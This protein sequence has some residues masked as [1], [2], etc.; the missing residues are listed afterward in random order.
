MG[1]RY[2]N[3]QDTE[4]NE[5]WCAASLS[6]FI[7]FCFCFQ[8]GIPARGMGPPTVRLRFL[9]SSKHLWKHSELF[10]FVLFRFF[11]WCA[12]LST[13]TRLQLVSW[14]EETLTEQLI[15]SNWPVPH[16]SM[17]GEDPA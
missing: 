17:M 13:S 7:C 14:V 15:P 4:K 6:F 2:V 5:C 1:S 8:S 3:S 16:C 12:N 9:F 10:R 11:Q